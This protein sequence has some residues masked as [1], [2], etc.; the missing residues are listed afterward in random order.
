MKP[1]L[2]LIALAAFPNSAAALSPEAAKGMCELAMRGSLM[3]ARAGSDV[4]GMTEAMMFCIQSGILKAAEVA[5][6]EADFKAVA[7]PLAQ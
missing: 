1:F 4:A 7:K 3:V 2:L 5:A 6:A